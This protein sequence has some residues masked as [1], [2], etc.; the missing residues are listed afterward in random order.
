MK[1]KIFA[2]TILLATCVF[3]QQDEIENEEEEIEV[4]DSVIVL[5]EDN[6]DSTIKTNNYFI[7]FYAPW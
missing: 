7:M 2:L 5:N 4:N 3:S 6:F 1:L